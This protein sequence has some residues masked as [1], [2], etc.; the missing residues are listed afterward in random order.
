MQGKKMF[1]IAGI[2]KKKS[3]FEGTNTMPKPSEVFQYFQEIHLV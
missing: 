2:K 3:F 1:D